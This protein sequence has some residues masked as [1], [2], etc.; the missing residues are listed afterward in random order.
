MGLEFEVRTLLAVSPERLYQAWLDSGEHSRMTGGVANVS[1]ETGAEF[2]AWDGYIQG[3]NLELPDPAHR[4]GLAYL[5][6]CRART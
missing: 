3:R 6:I 4:T 1:S 2:D 5:R